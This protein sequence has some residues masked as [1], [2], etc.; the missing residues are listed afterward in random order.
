MGLED[1]KDK[2]RRAFMSY[3]KHTTDELTAQIAARDTERLIRLAYIA[4][5]HRL[6]S[7]VEKLESSPSFKKLSLAVEQA[8]DKNQLPSGNTSSALENFF[9]R[10]HFYTDTYDNK[11]PKQELLFEL[12]WSSLP[13]RKVRT[14]R[15]RLKIQKFTKQE[16]DGLIDRQIRDVFYL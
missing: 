8:L 15:L 9:K 4:P 14:T 10:S 7:I 6:R 12:F 3:V 11:N 13:I 1:N 16:L 5:V 2:I